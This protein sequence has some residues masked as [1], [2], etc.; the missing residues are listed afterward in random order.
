MLTGGT[1]FAVSIP[2]I[3]WDRPA[4]RFERASHQL[5]FG[6]SLSARSLGAAAGPWPSWHLIC[7][8]AV[9][10]RLTNAPWPEL[11]VAEVVYGRDTDFSPVAR[12]TLAP[13]GGFDTRVCCVLVLRRQDALA[14]QATAI[15][16]RIDRSSPA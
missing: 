16:R 9:G 6:E 1:L 10:E 12:Q 7:S 3:E 5:A 13:A 14:V 8:A 4:H 11:F 2:H 15:E